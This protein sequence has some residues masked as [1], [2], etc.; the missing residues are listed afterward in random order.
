LHDRHTLREYFVDEAGDG[1]LFSSKG[2]KLLVGEN[3]CSRYFMLGLVYFRAGDDLVNSIA[4]LKARVL[5]DPSTNRIPSIAKR[6]GPKFMFHAKD[7]PTGVREEVFSIIERHLGSIRFLAVVRDK[8]SVVNYVRQRGDRN[9]SYRYNPNELYDSMVR[10]L[11]RDLLHRSDEYNIYFARRGKTPRT[12]ALRDALTRARERCEYKWG[13]SSSS[14]INVQPVYS[15]QQTALQVVDYMLWALQRYYEK[16]EGQHL[17]LIWP[18]VRLVVD[19]DDTSHA[20]Y[21]VYYTQK[22]PLFREEDLVAR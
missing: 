10:R 17:K 19:V 14:P 8:L 6:S 22:N 1:V 3:G 7:D 18:A 2:G 20:P 21:G 13:I 15:Y 9:E 11:F 16:G 4:G 5:G 12:E